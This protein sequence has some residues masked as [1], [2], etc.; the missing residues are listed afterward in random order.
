[1]STVPV[2]LWKK[3]WAK[4]ESRLFC[5]IVIWYY[6]RLEKNEKSPQDVLLERKERSFLSFI[7]HSLLFQSAKKTMA[8]GFST[9]PLTSIYGTRPLSRR[10]CHRK[11]RNPENVYRTSTNKNLHFWHW[12]LLSHKVFVHNLH[13]TFYLYLLPKVTCLS[14]NGKEKNIIELFLSACTFCVYNVWW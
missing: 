4:N 11:S 8:C 2:R 13:Y 7:L 10:F 3:G 1:M 14:K 5:L 6:R 12:A 9:H